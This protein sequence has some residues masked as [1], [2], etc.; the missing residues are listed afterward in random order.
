MLGVAFLEQNERLVIELEGVKRV[1]CCRLA[2]TFG[3]KETNSSTH[4][5]RAEET[6]LKALCLWSETL[7]I[8]LSYNK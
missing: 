2:F 3:S 8:S 6:E 4:E 1:P 5:H 7:N